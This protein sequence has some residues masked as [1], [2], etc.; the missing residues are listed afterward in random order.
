MRMANQHNRA[1][2]MW[3]L[4]LLARVVVIDATGCW[5]WPGAISGNGYGYT[6]TPFTKHAIGVHRAIFQAVRHRLGPKD[7]LDHL[8]NTP[9]CCNPWHLEIVTHGENTRRANMRRWHG[10]SG[11]PFDDAGYEETMTL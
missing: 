10:E 6:R 1:P 9:L 2:S 11:N 5:L 4:V 3:L 7:H 8:C